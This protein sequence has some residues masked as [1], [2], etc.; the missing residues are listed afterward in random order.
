[1]QACSGEIV[2]IIFDDLDES[3]LNQKN[4]NGGGACSAAFGFMKKVR[5]N[6]PRH[7]FVEPCSQ[8]AGEKTSPFGRK[9]I[10]AS[11]QR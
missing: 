11:V 4:L 5:K 9:N 7:L 2:L 8:V 10:H 3:V 6:Q 1:M